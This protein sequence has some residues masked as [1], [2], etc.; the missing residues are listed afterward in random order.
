[1]VIAC[2]QSH[3]SGLTL[4]LEESVTLR[5]LLVPSKRHHVDRSHSLELLFQTATG[6]VSSVSASA[7]RRGT[8]SCGAGQRLI[9]RSIEPALPCTSSSTVSFAA[10][11]VRLLRCHGMYPISERR[12]SGSAPTPSIARMQLA[13]SVDCAA[14]SR[15][16]LRTSASRSRSTASCSF[17]RVRCCSSA[18]AEG[19]LLLQLVDRRSRSPYM[20]SMR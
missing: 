14:S 11:A 15:A 12:P 19:Q 2:S 20:R 7:S 16:L 9:P 17:S 8:S 10:C 6:F 13:S 4:G 3:R 18:V 5:R 1:M